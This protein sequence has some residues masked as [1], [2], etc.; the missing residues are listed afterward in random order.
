MKKEIKLYLANETV[1][2]GYGPIIEGFEEI[3]VKRLRRKYKLKVSINEV[4][5]LIHKYNNI[6]SVGRSFLWDYLP[7]AKGEYASPGDF[8]Q[9]NFIA[10]LSNEFPT[11]DKDILEL[12][13]RW[14]VYCEYLL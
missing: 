4:T 3:M 11:V 7:P 12:I 2:G 13:G 14:I 6:Y 1:R 8:D 9:D 5:E 10:R